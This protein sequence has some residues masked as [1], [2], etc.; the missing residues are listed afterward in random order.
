[1]R[2][3]G[4]HV[5]GE[6]SVPMPVWVID[7]RHSVSEA[8]G[9]A[10][11]SIA[12]RRLVQVGVLLGAFAAVYASPIAELAGI[13]W[14]RDIY[15]HGFLVVPVSLYLAWTKRSELRRLTPEPAGAWGV[16]LLVVA[17][18]L[19]IVGRAGSIVGLQALSLVAMIIGLVAH[20]LGRRF[21]KALAF[22]AAYLTLMVPFWDEALGFLHWP[23]QLMAA[24]TGTRILQGLG[25][26]AMVD[27]QYIL[28][29]GA[30]L[31]VAETC[32]GVNYMVAIFAVALP[33][34]YLLLTRHWS[35]LLLFVAAAVV[36]VA[37]NS[38]RVVLIGLWALLGN[39]IVHGPLEIFQAMFVAWFGALAVAGMAWLLRALE[40]RTAQAA[41]TPVR[42]TVSA[43]PAPAA[44][45]TGAWA[46]ALGVL[47]LTGLGV[48]LLHRGAVVFADFDVVP[49]SLD[50]WIGHAGDI[51]DAV[52]RVH[53]ADQEML[54]VYR[55]RD[56]HAVQVYVAYL[57]GE[58][59]GKKLVDHRTAVLH[60]RAEP[61][62]LALAEGGVS[63]INRAQVR[64]DRR[65]YPVLF[66]YH[67]NGAVVA[68]R[69]RA[70]LEIARGALA[71]GRTNGALFVVAPLST[72][73]AAPPRWTDAFARTLLGSV[74][75][76]TL[77]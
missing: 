18:L 24:A 28:L 36:G 14:T 15:S 56:G 20:L 58:R 1:M 38:V 17:S 73:D 6:P 76:F 22:P 21:V 51:R 72:D 62:T 70:K 44:R 5:G 50:G 34:G 66:W 55:D 47:A 27:R 11:A 60:E 54:R 37:A 46:T 48:A 33:L 63:T 75:A 7:A 25:V 45:F 69:Y 77:L 23:L 74:R 29:P 12:S 59:S 8:S 9:A 49:R 53:A 26:A 13:W 68:D 32:S 35:R 71:H 57:T 3:S 19:L 31:E 2:P 42:E 41:P 43:M 67:L 52:F 4:S 30:A 65:T 40:W 64:H 16:T 61:L 10:P 39:E